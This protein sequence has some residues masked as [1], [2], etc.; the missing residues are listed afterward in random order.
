MVEVPVREVNRIIG[1]HI[2]ITDTWETVDARGDYSD[3]A[4]KI[5][6]A[7]EVID[8]ACKLANVYSTGHPLGRGEIIYDCGNKKPRV[9][10]HGDWTKEHTYIELHIE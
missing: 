7:L 2:K 10:V 8:K 6:T 1:K 4:C 5:L 3:D 9:V